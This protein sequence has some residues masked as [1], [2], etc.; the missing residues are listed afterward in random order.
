MTFALNFTLFYFALLHSARSFALL[1]LGSCP[2]NSTLLFLP[3][4][5]F[6]SI[7]LYSTL[8]YPTLPTLPYFT[9]SQTLGTKANEPHRYT[10]GYIRRT[11]S[12]WSDGVVFLQKSKGVNF[13]A[14]LDHGRSVLIVSVFLFF[15]FSLLLRACSFVLHFYTLHLGNYAFCVSFLWACGLWVVRLIFPSISAGVFFIYLILE[16]GPAFDVGGQGKFEL[17]LGSM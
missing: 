14:S 4:S 8:L 5:P 17:R 13:Y 9:S 7:P 12:V 2:L 10:A 1:P 16:L 6:P 15:F 11:K 3:L